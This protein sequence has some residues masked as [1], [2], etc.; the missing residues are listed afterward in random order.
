MR[1]IK[2]SG[3]K[4]KRT[5]PPIRLD[6]SIELEDP[7]T[8]EA[9]ENAES[10]TDRRATKRATKTIVDMAWDAFARQ[11]VKE[12]LVDESLGYGDLARR[13]AKFGLTLTQKVVCRRVSRGH[14]SGGFFLLC[15]QA[16]QVTRIDFYGE[17]SGA[18]KVGAEITVPDAYKNQKPARKEI[19]AQSVIMG[20]AA[21]ESSPHRSPKKQ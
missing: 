18:A 13:L 19:S 7:T 6:D 8:N 21:E 17:R 9:Y 11:L 15:M 12:A 16:L 5:G 20:W 14:F 1:K 4:K 10:P 2:S 3:I